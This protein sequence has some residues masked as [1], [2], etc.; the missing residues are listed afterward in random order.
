MLKLDYPWHEVLVHAARSR[1]ELWR[2]IAGCIGVVT[3]VFG[4]I[5]ALQAV[6]MAIAPDFW[7]GQM[8]DPSTQGSTAGSLIILLGTFGFLTVGVAVVAQILHGR[9]P[10]TVFGPWPVLVS[11]FVRVFGFL[12]L[13]GVALM[14]LPPYGDTADLEANLPL[15]RWLLLLPVSL[16]VVLIQTSAEEVFFRGYLQQQLAA[17]FSSP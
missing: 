4:L 5:A 1:P 9:S 6:L 14:V 8:A 17:R 15:A 11:Q 3:I 2:L 7:I 12:C 10:V 13:L 16:T